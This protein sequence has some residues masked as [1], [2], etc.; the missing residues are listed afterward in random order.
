VAKIQ[1]R[2]KSILMNPVIQIISQKTGLLLTTSAILPLSGYLVPTVIFLSW[3][4]RYLSDRC[5][6]YLFIATGAI[7]YFATSANEAIRTTC[8]LFASLKL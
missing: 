8:I 7:V 5:D 3:T 6:Y 2:S 4:A 1:E